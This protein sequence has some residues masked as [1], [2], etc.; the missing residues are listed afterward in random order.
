MLFLGWGVGGKV[1][2]GG[3][4]VVGG[5]S[6]RFG[7]TFGSGGVLLYHNPILKNYDGTLP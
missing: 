6:G 5:G 7:G 4:G 3:L 1:R 2:S